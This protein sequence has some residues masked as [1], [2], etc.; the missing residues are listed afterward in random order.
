[1]N[2]ETLHLHLDT[3]QNLVAREV[4]S[5]RVLEISLQ[6]PGSAAQT[7]RVPLNLALVL[8]RSGSM[9]GEKLEYVKRAAEHVLDLLHEQDMAAVV[10]YDD[11][12]NLLSPSVAVT[13]EQRSQL[14]RLISTLRPGGSTNLSGGWLAGCQE[15]AAAAARVSSTGML[16]RCL[17][18]T[19]GLANVGIT[20]L[21]ALAVHA[22]E[23]SRRGVSTSTFGV[24]EGFNEHLLE[25][26]SNQGGGSF[27]YIETP[28]EIP[29]LFEREFKEL[30]AVTAREIEIVLEFPANVSLQVL[31]GWVSEF[32]QGRLSIS[33]GS[34]Y[35]N[36][37]QQIFIKVLTP[38]A[39]AATDLKISARITGMDE[40]GLPFEARAELA[41]QYTG[42][43]SAEAAPKK[44]EVLERF[45]Q[46]DLAETANEALKL[47]RQGKREQANKMLQQSIRANA[48]HIAASQA[49]EYQAISEKMQDGM[50][51]ADRKSSHY[52][53]YNQKRQR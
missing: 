22:R 18:L 52:Q 16:S 39:A 11:E 35:A 37:S 41:F 10:A 34:M 7:N 28:S 15:A 2:T 3:D 36:K 53:A 48:P 25:A 49:A 27:Y 29:A 33:L 13:G 46:V 31:G 51:E 17:L 24:G 50:T 44:R 8:D 5:Q 23:L 26:I 20:D 40:A 43:V 32:S 12:I 47:E 9:S 45:A 1:M 38:P 42:L 4:P 21:E 14:K 30:A 19:D 6:A